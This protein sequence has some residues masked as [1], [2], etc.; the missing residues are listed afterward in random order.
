MANELTLPRARN[1]LSEAMLA[2]RDLLLPMLRRGENLEWVTGAL[3]DLGK[4]E[5]LEDLIGLLD[6]PRPDL[7]F[8]SI[9]AVWAIVDQNKDRKVRRDWD[10]MHASL[11]NATH[12][13]FPP[14]AVFAALILAEL[15]QKLD[16]KI[17]QRLFNIDATG[18]DFESRESFYLSKQLN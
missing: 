16:P 7:R 14:V 4:S 17:L 12:D 6:N 1:A 10:W 3:G 5:A 18:A 9:A 2:N 13:A 8:L 15:G 11:R